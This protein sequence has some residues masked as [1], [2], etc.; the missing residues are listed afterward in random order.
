MTDPMAKAESIER[1]K[2]Q[3]YHKEVWAWL[4]LIF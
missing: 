3:E 2:G 4:Y 1:Y